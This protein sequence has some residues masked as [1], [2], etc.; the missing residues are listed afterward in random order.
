MITGKLNLSQ[1]DPHNRRVQTMNV[2]YLPGARQFAATQ[3]KLLFPGPLNFRFKIRHYLACVIGIDV[4]GWR[5]AL[6]KLDCY[7]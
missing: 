7:R 1:W 3:L 2:V 6:A 4:I 5:R